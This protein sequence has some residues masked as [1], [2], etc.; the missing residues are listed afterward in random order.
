VIL[1]TIKDYC[2]DF[3]AKL[4]KNPASSADGFYLDKNS[5]TDIQVKVE[6]FHF[7]NY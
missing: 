1:K 5:L 7:N 4:N 2:G 3:N 6:M